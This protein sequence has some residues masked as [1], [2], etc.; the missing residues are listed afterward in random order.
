M[1]TQIITLKDGVRIEAEV[2]RSKVGRADEKVDQTIDSVTP[3]LVKVVKPLADAWDKLAGSVQVEKAEI[4][5]AVGFEA[6]GNFFVA[7]AKG[8]ANLKI[9]LILSKPPA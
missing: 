6:S 4:E 1:P 5:V 9:K 8:N 7:S 3:M 2:T